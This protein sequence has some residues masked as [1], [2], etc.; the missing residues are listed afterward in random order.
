ML[1]VETVSTKVLG[2]RSHLVLD[3]AIAI[4]IDPQ[5]YVYCVESLLAQLELAGVLMLD[6]RRADEW[7]EGQIQ[8]SVQ[9]PLDGLIERLDELPHERLRVRCAS[10]CRAGISSSLHDRANRD[11]VFVDDYFAHTQS[12]GLVD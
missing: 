10:G 5:R 1:K 11:V 7:A 2:D 12:L 3:G 6:F 8:G 9:I 4:V